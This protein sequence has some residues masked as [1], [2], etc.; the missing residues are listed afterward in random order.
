MTLPFAP[1]NNKR[2]YQCFV[3][4]VV[5]ETY[6]EMKKHV[7]EEHEEGREYLV[8]PVKHCGC[9]VRDMRFHFRTRHPSLKMPKTGQLRATVMYDVRTPNKR[10]KLPTFKEGFLI[11]EKNNGKQMHYRSGY[12]K[13]VYEALERIGDILK[14]DVEPFAIDYFFRGKK[15]QYFPDLIVEYGDGTVEVWEVKPSNQTVLAQNKAK[16]EAAKHYCAIR[17]WGF[18]VITEQ[19]IQQLKKQAE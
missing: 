1:N 16:W 3:C 4:G 14:Y 15:K 9:P 2:K 6:D 18:D 13:D 10:K 7:F 5:F 19:R 17:G 8:C 12:E 11:S